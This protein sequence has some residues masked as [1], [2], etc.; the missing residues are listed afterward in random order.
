MYLWSRGQ[1]ADQASRHTR[2]EPNSAP[3]SA[4]AAS[5]VPAAKSV[6]QRTHGD[7]NKFPGHGFEAASYAA[8]LSAREPTTGAT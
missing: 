7:P 8:K 6:K 1:D 4:V 5:G 3:A 2:G